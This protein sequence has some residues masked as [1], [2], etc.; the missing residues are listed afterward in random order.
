MRELTAL[1]RISKVLD[2]MNYKT[3]YIEIQTET[4]KY[5]LEKENRTRVIGFSAGGK[6][7]HKQKHK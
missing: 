1:N 6:N 3:A 4:D 7:E 2:N 5:V